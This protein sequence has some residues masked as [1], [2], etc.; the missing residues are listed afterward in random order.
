MFGKYKIILMILFILGIFSFISAKETNEDPCFGCDDDQL[1]LADNNFENPLPVDMDDAPEFDD[2]H[3]RKDKFDRMK[4]RNEFRNNKITPEL[5]NK[6]INT[7][8]THFPEMHSK[9]IVLKKDHPEIYGRLIQ[10]L[11]RHIRRTKEP[12][13]EKKELISMIFDEC[14]VDILIKN[15]KNSKNEEEKEKLKVLIREK[16]SEGFDRRENL[17]KQVIEKIEKNIQ[18]KKSDHKDRIKN[19]E[20]LVNEHLEELLK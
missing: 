11:K 17:Q 7:L 10:K 1:F 15:Y 18:K 20:K 16:L 4:K 5:E 3:P 19:K 12:K 2:E 13:E 9:I 14:E 6:I 8:K